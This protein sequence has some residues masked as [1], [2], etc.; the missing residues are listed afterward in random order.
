MGGLLLDL[1][2]YFEDMVVDGSGGRE[3]VVA[4]DFVEQGI[5]GDH[6]LAMLDE[7]PENFRFE[8]SEFL[9]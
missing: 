7:I 9:L 5:P 2:S 3:G 6:F 4:P 1:F 8:R